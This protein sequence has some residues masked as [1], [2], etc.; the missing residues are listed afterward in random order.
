MRSHWG[1]RASVMVSFAAGGL[2]L[3]VVLAA[4][5]YFVVRHYLVDQRE[6]TATRQAF[7]D[8]SFV[9]DGLLTSGAQ[10]S[11]VLGNAAP[12]AD[13]D[14][15]VHR[16]GRW[17]SSSLR[18][19]AHNVPDTVRDSVR[20]G[21]AAVLWGRSERGPTIVVGVPL[22]AVDAEVY[23]IS[24]PSELSSTLSTLGAVL[25]GFALVTTLGGALLGRAAARRVVAPLD[26]VA[27]AATQISVGDLSTRLPPTDDPDL[28]AIVGSFNAMVE[29]LDERIAR[30]ARFAADISHELRSPLTTLVTSVDL[31]QRRRDELPQ[32]SRQAL[33]LIAT[34]LERFQRSLEDLLELG[35]LD[36]GVALRSLSDVDLRELVRYALES[37]HRDVPLQLPDGPLVVQ[38]DKQQLS[39]A[40]VNLFD[41]ADL[42]AGGLTAVRAEAVGDHAV[43]TVD[44]EGPG[45]PE[46]E[47]ERIFERFVRAGSRGSRRGTGLGLSIV[48]ETVQSLGGNVGCIDRPG[49]GARF[50]VRLPLAR[51]ATSADAERTRVQ[52]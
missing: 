38:V 26:D 12:P 16:Y 28:A 6:R 36:A 25:A 33:D 14:I 23:E 18:A 10:V 31:L 30:D 8:A 45:V 34:E 49:G 11:D 52:A 47:R 22:G 24:R 20:G 35:R 48:A 7:A 2:L 32:R 21:S 5:A 51:I 41:N 44:D 4:G 40:L 27:R 19:D 13:T 39:R 42:H 46:S 17:F 15:L 1:L 9:R 43:V 3:S 50:V 29:A 37:G